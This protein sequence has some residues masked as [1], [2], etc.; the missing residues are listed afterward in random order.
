MLRDNAENVLISAVTA[1]VIIQVVRPTTFIG[2]GFGSVAANRT[3]E[4]L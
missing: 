1:H 2:G 4:I 3:N